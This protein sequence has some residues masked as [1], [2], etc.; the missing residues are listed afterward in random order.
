MK[1]KL[2]YR[3]MID[4]ADDITVQ[5]IEGLPDDLQVVLRALAPNPRGATG[6]C[7]DSVLV[8]IC[9]DRQTPSAGAGAGDSALGTTPIA[10]SR[11]RSNA[12]SA[13][14]GEKMLILSPM[15]RRSAKSLSRG[16]RAA[17]RDSSYA[18]RR[19]LRPADEATKGVAAY[20][21]THQRPVLRR[22]GWRSCVGPSSVSGGAL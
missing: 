2:A 12:T 5:T 10:Y 7:Q 4:E 21:R 13:R 22:S 18:E 20:R 3:M 6:D 11:S 14:H 9:E 15:A 8:P 17:G 19:R 16:F 1:R